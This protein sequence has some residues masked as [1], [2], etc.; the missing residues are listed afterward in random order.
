MQT[1]RPRLRLAVG[2]GLALATLPATAMATASPATISTAVSRGATWIAS[3]QGRTAAGATGTGALT[4]G[5]LPGFNGNWAVTS[6]AS[7]GTNAVDVFNSAAPTN[8]TASLQAFTN[9]TYQSGGAYA[10]MGTL[11]AS[12]YVAGAFGREG[13]IA[14]SAG[15][16][17][18]KLRSDLSLTA[19]LASKW[20]A[21][22]GDFGAFAPNSD[23]FALLATSS[24]KLPVGVREKIVTNLLASQ[25]TSTT[26]DAAGRTA[27]GG[28]SY[29]TGTSGSGDIDMTGAV[30]SMLC[31]EGKTTADTSIAN[32]VDFLHRR[33]NAT[34]GGFG[35]ST[36]NSIPPNNV[37]SAA[38]ALIGLKACGVDP[39]SATWTTTSGKNPVEF[40]LDQQRLPSTPDLSTGSFK[41]VSTT[42]YPAAQYDMNST[43][44]ATRALSNY[45]W[46]APVPAAKQLTPPTVNSGTTVPIALSVDNR[47]G[48]VKF[49][50]VSVPAGT[51]TLGTLLSTAASSSIP[52]GCVSSPVFTGS[53]L[54]SV[55]GYANGGGKTWT[56]RRNGGAS[57][58]PTNQTV[59]FGDVFAL[60]L[61]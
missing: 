29:T 33:L 47:A 8:V 37:P 14:S 22:N 15:L 36:E 46:S 61:N 43:E 52:S 50:E 44:A 49:C 39:Q 55:N 31:Q 30:L 13:L 40:L 25:K 3:M 7:A 60:E 28:W 24:L 58:V 45:R 23:G 42:A 53:T 34:T 4:D 51:T 41:Y 35:T 16:S 18:T 9:T 32:G 2:A 21:A 12:G 1:P 27:F 54:T 59:Q 17:V 10:S 48:D 5:S 19:S 11:P 38:W 56:L 20:R 57:E 6:L 26:P